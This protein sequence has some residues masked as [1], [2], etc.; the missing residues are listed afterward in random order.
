[1]K[2]YT[3]VDYHGSLWIIGQLGSYI[4][5][6]PELSAGFRSF[7]LTDSQMMQKKTEHMQSSQLLIFQFCQRHLRQ[8]GHQLRVM[9]SETSVVR[10]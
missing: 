10:F 1:M 2:M 9:R 4:P 5:N 6:R 3:L 7:E 8:S